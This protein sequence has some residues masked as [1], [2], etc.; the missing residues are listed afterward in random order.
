MR[1]FVL[2]P[3]S[4]VAAAIAWIVVVMRSKQP[5]APYT[6]KVAIGINLLAASP[7]VLVPV[8]EPSW[9]RRTYCVSASET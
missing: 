4:L 6:S 1:Y 9:L 7:V 2:I 8:Q 3:V 5:D